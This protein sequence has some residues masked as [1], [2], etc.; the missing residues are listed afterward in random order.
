MPNL[1]FSFADAHI[2]M[3]EGACRAKSPN[4]NCWTFGRDE[5]GE[6]GSSGMTVRERRR[7]R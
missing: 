6:D 5:A 1:R 3:R 7:D 2:K 4:A